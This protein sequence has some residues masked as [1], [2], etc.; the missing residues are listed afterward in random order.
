M[1]TLLSFALLFMVVIRA[2]ADCSDNGL[3]VFPG[4]KT[5][6]QNTI[7]MIQGY[8]S[9]QWIVTKLGK[10][11]PVYLK[12][13]DTKVNLVVKE[14]L[15]GQFDLTQAILEP[16][17][18]LKTGLK[19]ELI[20]DNLPEHEHFER[21]NST[22]REYEPFIFEVI[23]GEDTEK[24]LFLSRPQEISK[25][26]AYFGC[27]PAMSVNFS[28]LVSDSSEFLV[29]ATV[30]NLVTG[31]STPYYIGHGDSTVSIGH[32]MC[33]GAFVFKG[34]DDYEVTFALLDVAGNS[35][36]WVGEP[37]KFTKPEEAER[38]KPVITIE[39]K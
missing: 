4:G 17:S 20:I 38:K 12:S 13:G 35:T 3:S 23:E 31:V 22:I 39:D 24:P 19:Y 25:S 33:S 10:A 5:I 34:N 14:T 18:G 8:A 6:R 1:K 26:I 9:S 30:K 2:N 32:N 29:K 11:Y 28:C 37:I 15:M 7:I 27:G 16:E 36:E 21:W